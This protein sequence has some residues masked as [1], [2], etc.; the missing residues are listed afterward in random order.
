MKHILSLSLST[1]E[2]VDDEAFILVKAAPRASQT[3]GETVCIAA[4]DRTG[5]WCRLYPVSFRYMEQRQRF[6]RW[7]RITY[8][9]R[10]PPV[11]QD[12]RSESR[13]VDDSSIEIIGTLPKN[14]RHALVD[15]IGVTSLARQL[16]QHRS[17]AMLKC[18]IIDF[19]PQRRTSGELDARRSTYAALERQGDLLAALSDVIPRDPC[20]YAFKYRYR[21]DDGV[22]WG[23]CQD[24]E[25]EATFMR[26]LFEM[27]E[28][29]ALNWMQQKFG[30]EY[31]REGMALAMGTHRWHPGQWL[32]NGVIRYDESPQR[33]LL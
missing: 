33:R 21:D 32:I 11:A 8:R 22:H 2:H 17:L 10:R 3:H 19:V 15:R 23:T 16:E 29:P 31:A 14:Q 25:T 24:W 26:R 9:W 13:R 27:G 5:A 30:E 18:E 7:D 12:R 28:Q 1:L 4:V 6:G 20:P